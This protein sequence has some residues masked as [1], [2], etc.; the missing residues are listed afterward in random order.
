[1]NRES[2]HAVYT[3]SCTDIT[4]GSYKAKVGGKPRFKPN[5][6]VGISPLDEMSWLKGE[7]I[8]LNIIED[9]FDCHVIESNGL[10]GGGCGLI[11]FKDCSIPDLEFMDFSKP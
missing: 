1:M 11:D 10:E 7:D 4:K 5:S 8:K 9:T 2:N 3:V 6:K